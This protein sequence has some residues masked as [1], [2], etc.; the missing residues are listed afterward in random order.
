M[1]KAARA[2]P[3][4]RMRADHVRRGMPDAQAAR[5]GII[6]GLLGA[7]EHEQG[8][9]DA[10]IEPVGITQDHAD[11]E[12]DAKQRAED[13]R[14]KTSETARLAPAEDHRHQRKRQPRG[15]RPCHQHGHEHEHERQQQADPPAALAS[16]QQHE[17]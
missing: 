15:A 10:R 2:D 16:D 1:A 8:S 9:L 12:G 11:A 13:Q 4:E 3:G 17:R 6:D 14:K 7:L 5:R